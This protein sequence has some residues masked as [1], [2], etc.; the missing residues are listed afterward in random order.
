MK[1]TSRC[2]KKRPFNVK[3]IHFEIFPAIAGSAKEVDMIAEE[4]IE[5]EKKYNRIKSNA[6]KEFLP[7]GTILYHGSLNNN[8]NFYNHGITYFGLDPE[9]SLWYILELITDKQWFFNKNKI[10]YMYVVELKKDLYI[11][12]IILDIHDNPRSCVGKVCAHPQ[13]AIIMGNESYN[14]LYTEITIDFSENKYKDIIDIID[15][16][17][18]DTNVLKKNAKKNDFDP[19]HSIYACK[20]YK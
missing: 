1:N 9:I 3:S 19:R 18:I 14:K 10:G 13:A 8:V 16:C 2:I 5:L 15:I 12:K 11:D 20:T 17:V 4:L 6:S 7:K